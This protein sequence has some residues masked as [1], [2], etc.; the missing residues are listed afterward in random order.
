MGY[1]LPI[2]HHQ[3]REYHKRVEMNRERALGIKPVHKTSTKIKLNEYQ[4]EKYH[5]NHRLA[6]KKRVEYEPLVKEVDLEIIDACYA[7]ITGTGLN[8]NEYA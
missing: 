6:E 3:Y 2:N 5:E 7:E 8:F 1:I 4:M